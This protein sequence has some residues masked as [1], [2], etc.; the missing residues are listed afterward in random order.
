MITKTQ[1]ITYTDMVIRIYSYP[2]GLAGLDCRSRQQQTR[3]PRITDP[4]K[5]MKPGKGPRS[6]DHPLRVR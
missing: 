4:Q 5:E 3:I 1:A 2:T 6:V